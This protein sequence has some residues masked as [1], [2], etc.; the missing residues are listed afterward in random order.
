MTT[1]I[2]PIQQQ[3]EAALK[4]KRSFIGGVLPFIGVILF[5]IVTARQFAA[6]ADANWGPVV[7]ANAV[8]YLIG[9]AGVGAG[10]SHIFFGKRISKTIGF[11]KSPYELE[12]GFA[13]LAFGIVALMASSFSPEFSLAI[14]LV[15]SIFRVGC[16]IGHIRSMIQERNFAPN[17]TS[18][19]FVNFVVPAFLLFAYFTWM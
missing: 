14:I 18:I 11:A 7:V 9:Y 1:T 15:S 5:V 8:V 13:D 10:I 2:E 4:H 19:L 12:V 17:N 3:P 6:G 16:G